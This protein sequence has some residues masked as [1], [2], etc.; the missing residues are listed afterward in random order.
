M[1]E[2][3]KMPGFTAEASLY[4]PRRHYN[5]A[6]NRGVDRHI[7]IPQRIRDLCNLNN[8]PDS[9]I[10][11]FVCTDLCDYPREWCQYTCYGPGADPRQ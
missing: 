8:Y 3:I 10:C 4:K 7:V 11:Y 6:V 9:G 2:G 1:K 5:L